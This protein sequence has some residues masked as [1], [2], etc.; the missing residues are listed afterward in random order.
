MGL[1][2]FERLRDGQTLLGA[3]RQARMGPKERQDRS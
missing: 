2:Q 1:G 3:E